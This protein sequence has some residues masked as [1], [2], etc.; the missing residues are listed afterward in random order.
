MPKPASVK[1]E[2]ERSLPAVAHDVYR[3]FLHG[4]TYTALSQ[5]FSLD[6]RTV[7]KYV[8]ALLKEHMPRRGATRDRL[9]GEMLAK[10]ARVQ[11]QAWEASVTDPTDMSALNIIVRTIREQ[12]KLQGLYEDVTVSVEHK[13][14]VEIHVVYKNDW[15]GGGG[16]IRPTNVGNAGAALTAPVVDASVSEVKG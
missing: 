7:K 1:T 3:G 11:Q 15:R 8:D 6:P 9:R 10:L 16:Q 14:A 2:Q 13:G 12:A 4:K 5:E